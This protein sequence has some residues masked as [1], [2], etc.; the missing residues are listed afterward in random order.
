MKEKP[1]LFS[2]PMVQAILNGCKS[3]TRRE[4]KS[5]SMEQTALMIN[6]LSGLESASEELMRFCRFQVGDILWVRET[7]K[8]GFWDHEEDIMAFDYKASPDL[9]KTK[10]VEFQDCDRFNKMTERAIEELDSLGIEPIIDEESET[11]HYKWESGQSPFKWKPSIH[12]PKEASRIFLKITDIRIECV[13]DISE[14]DAISE[15]VER[16]SPDCGYRNYLD[17]SSSGCFTA[18][19]S[20]KTLWQSINGLESWERNPLVLVI[21]FEICDK[22]KNFIS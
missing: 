20:F 14:K 11:F 3:E 22:P 17:D 15:G 13:Q 12:M 9:T 2:A 10:R 7:W 19:D 16:L 6:L 18:K 8:I 5:G 21:S 1:I 4:I